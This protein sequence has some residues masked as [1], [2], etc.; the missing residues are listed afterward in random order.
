[1]VNTPAIFAVDIDSYLVGVTPG[2][3][4]TASQDT[5]AINAA[6][7]DVINASSANFQARVRF[8]GRHYTI[9]A[10]IA[11][12]Q[13]HS[14]LVLEGVHTNTQ[15]FR[16]AGY[17]GKIFSFTGAPPT[18]ARSI[19]MRRLVFNMGNVQSVVV[20]TNY[21]L[22][23]QM[24][25]CFFTNNGDTFV[26]LRNTFDS[27]IVDCHF[28]VGG[29]A[30][31]PGHACLQI[32][33]DDAAQPCNNIRVVDC[34]FE[35]FS[36]PAITVK[37][38]P[39]IGRN[40]NNITIRGCKMES[41]LR[42]GSYLELN[43]GNQCSVKECL[44]Y[45]AAGTS[46]SAIHLQQWNGLI[47]DAQLGASPGAS[48]QYFLFAEAD[49]GCIDFTCY[50]NDLGDGANVPKLDKVVGFVVNNCIQARVMG[51]NFASSYFSRANVNPI[52]GTFG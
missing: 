26:N 50:V 34:R 44:F 20:E 51:Y 36:G 12:T 18:F 8:G 15:I 28:Q 10:E 11:L 49:A 7:A 43:N 2:T 30:G 46:Q 1:M 22:Y 19:L 31:S 4:P 33:T 40:N 21:C 14:N 39:G 45:F 32:L 13:A 9:N 6:I 24:E 5:A 42:S 37:S 52:G 29:L 41:N 35:T 17:T 23:F 3:Q 25:D 27:K 47:G 38:N 16:A 48:L